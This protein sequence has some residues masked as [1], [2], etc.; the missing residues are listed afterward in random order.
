VCAIQGFLV[1]GCRGSGLQPARRR[2]N[3]FWDILRDHSY[4]EPMRLQDRECVVV[5]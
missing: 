5:L 2:I 1:A 3:V 4:K